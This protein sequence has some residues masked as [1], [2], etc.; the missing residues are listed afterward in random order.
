MFK[1]CALL[2]T[3]RYVAVASLDIRM[4]DKKYGIIDTFQGGGIKCTNFIKS[5]PIF[6]SLLCF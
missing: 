6:T 3:Q 2:L 5:K 1:S 4:G